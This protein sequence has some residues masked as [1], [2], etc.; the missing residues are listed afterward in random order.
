M[1]KAAVAFASS[2]S[3]AAAASGVGAGAPAASGTWRG[4]S[5]RRSGTAAPAAARP[6]SSRC[7]RRRGRGGRSPSWRT[8]SGGRGRGPPA[9]RTGRAASPPRPAAAHLERAAPAARTTSGRAPTPRARRSGSGAAARRRAHRGDGERRI[10]AWWSRPTRIDAD[11]IRSSVSSCCFWACLR[12]HDRLAEH[13]VLLEAR[14]HRDRALREGRLPGSTTPRPVRC[15]SVG[16]SRT[17]RFRLIPLPPNRGMSLHESQRPHGKFLGSVDGGTGLPPS[18]RA[19]PV[20]PGEAMSEPSSRYK[21]E[22]TSFRLSRVIKVG[23]SPREPCR[24]ACSAG[25]PN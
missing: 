17:H 6:G 22:P 13:A 15:V 18:P 10:A 25:S 14:G 12:G 2:S 19:L 23:N 16:G 24:G 11:R 1:K 7:R 3:I 4:Q 8:T 20:V 9:R 21:R 5:G